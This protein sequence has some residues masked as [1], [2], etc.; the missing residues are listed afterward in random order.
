MTFE[1]ELQERIDSRTKP[2]GSLGQLERIASKV[3]M[4]HL[5]AMHQLRLGRRGL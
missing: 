3:G 4:I 1:E 5:A 2:K